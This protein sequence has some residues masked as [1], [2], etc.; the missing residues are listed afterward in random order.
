MWSVVQELLGFSWNPSCTADVFRF[1]DGC[2][3]QTRRV[4]STCCA[5]L[6]W[7]LW[8]IRNKFTIEEKYPSQ[9]ADIIF[10][11]FMYLQVWKPVARRQDRE[12]LEMTIK[13]IHSL[14]ADG[15]DLILLCIVS[16]L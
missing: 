14:H 15:A 4:L 7:F 11:K 12:A 3:G 1:L 9:P 8:N 5:A 6:L 2:V 13:R 10:K 16:V